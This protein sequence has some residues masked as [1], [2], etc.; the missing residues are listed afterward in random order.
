MIGLR[1]IL[2]HLQL[3]S[4]IQAGSSCLITLVCRKP[5][6]PLSLKIP[7]ETSAFVRDDMIQ[8]LGALPPELVRSVTLDQGMEFAKHTEISAALGD[9]S[10]FHRLT[11]HGCTVQ[12][13][14][15]TV[16]S[17]NTVPNLLTWSL[18]LLRS[19]PLLPTKSIFD[20][21]NASN[22]DLPLKSSLVNCRI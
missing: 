16:L 18:S 13:R 21:A 17:G 3:S 2:I 7:K 6:L 15:S 22:G 4:E 9:I 14:T 1:K 8:L 20:Y 19:S 11:R 10:F 12:T 5:R